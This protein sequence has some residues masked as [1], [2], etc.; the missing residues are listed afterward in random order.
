MS[1]SDS[2]FSVQHVSFTVRILSF[3]R[4]QRT[5]FLLLLSWRISTASSGAGSTTRGSC[6]GSTATRA[7]VQEQVLDILALESLPNIRIQVSRGVYSGVRTLAKRVVQMGSTSSIFAALMSDWSLSAWHVLVSLPAPKSNCRGSYGDVDTVIREDES[8]VGG[9]E[10]RGRHCD[11]G[12]DECR[13]YWLVVFR[14]V[15]D[16]VLR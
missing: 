4:L 5:L 13:G 1:S 7:D 8:G 15:E 6:W 10:L 9:C 16:D 12:R 11:V 3:G 2:S 14:N